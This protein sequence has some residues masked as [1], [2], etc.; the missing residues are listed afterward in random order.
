MDFVDFVRRRGD[1]HLHTA[2]LLTGDW[3]AAQDLTQAA[4]TELYRVWERLDTGTEPDAYLRRIMVNTRRSWW[5]ARWRRET[6]LAEIPD[7]G[8][9]DDAAD[10]HAVAEVVR[11]AL[12]SLPPRQRTALVLRYF[13]DLSEA[14][15]AELMRISVGSVK[16]HAHRG[17]AA[18]R[19]S[20]PKDLLVV[21]NEGTERGGVER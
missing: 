12:R 21:V 5:R 2:V 15:T 13:E 3:Q 6:P 20:L 4:L 16:T 1:R 18:L 10:R 9:A 7:R 8:S 17:L 14:Q 19:A 11:Q